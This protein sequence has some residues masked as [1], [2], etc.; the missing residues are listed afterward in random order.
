L[1]GSPEKAYCFPKPIHNHEEHNMATQDQAGSGQTKTK[2]PLPTAEE[3][4]ALLDYDRETGDFRWL[5]ANSGRVRVGDV[6]GNQQQTG[7][8]VIGVN[9]RLYLA[10]RLA[11]LWVTGE[12]PKGQIDHKDGDRGNNAI[13]NLREVSRSE[14]QQNR[15]KEATRSG[16]PTSSRFLGVYRHTTT[17]RWMAYISHNGKQKNLGL[18]ATQEE[19]Y[20]AYLAAKAV[21]HNAQPIPRDSAYDHRDAAQ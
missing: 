8:L 18:F 5:K 17:G 19:A 15:R 13:D 16:R 6:A 10:H 21:L 4:R 12:W 1:T 7:Y 3:V 20:A 9:Y 2:R 11:W 14:N